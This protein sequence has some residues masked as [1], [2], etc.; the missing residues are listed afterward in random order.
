MRDIRVVDNGGKLMHIRLVGSSRRR[1]RLL[2]DERSFVC[3]SFSC[4][5]GFVYRGYCNMLQYVVSVSSVVFSG[6]EDRHGICK[7]PVGKICMRIVP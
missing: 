6:V 4:R 3:I 5:L 7:G 1:Y 2:Y